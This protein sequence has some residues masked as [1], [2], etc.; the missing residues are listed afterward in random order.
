M[1][2]AEAAIQHVEAEHRAS[3]LQIKF[4]KIHG[5]VQEPETFE[6]LRRERIVCKGRCW[7]RPRQ[8]QFRRM[9]ELMAVEIV[10]TSRSAVILR[11]MQKSIKHTEQRSV[12]CSTL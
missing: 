7:V 11:P 8:V 10:E 12:C 4:A 6:F 2:S 1:G 9:A 3:K 5:D